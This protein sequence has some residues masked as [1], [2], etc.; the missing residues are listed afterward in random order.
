MDFS[1]HLK[2]SNTDEWYSED[3]DSDA[4][5]A[6]GTECHPTNLACL[7]NIDNDPCE[8]DNLA[9]SKSVLVE[10][11]KE[12][13]RRFNTTV[14]YSKQSASYRADDLKTQGGCWAPVVG[15]SSTLSC[16]YVLLLTII[17][18]SFLTS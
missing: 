3:P 12:K 2:L 6:L 14:N 13:L 4:C 18:N 17:L 8:K 7:F 9:T 1:K 16:S 11:I 5:Q 15:G 10:D